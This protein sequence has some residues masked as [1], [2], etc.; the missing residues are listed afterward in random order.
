MKRKSSK[1]VSLILITATLASCST[2]EPEQSQVQRV[3]MRAD[4]SA[5]Y[6][7]VTEQYQQGRSYGTG[8][9]GSAL[10]WYMAFRP[11]M[12]Q[13][14]RA[15]GYTSSGLSSASNIG[16]NNQKGQVAKT[17]QRGGFGNTA[18]EKTAAS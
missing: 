8:S 14:G 1:T 13:G 9:M 10:L 17:V 18:N 2:K 7:E 5:P 6:Q 15:M 3:Y 4:Q 12:S 16:N 11:L